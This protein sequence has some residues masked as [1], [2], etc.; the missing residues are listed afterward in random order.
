MIGYVW[1]PC[2]RHAIPS[3]KHCPWLMMALWHDCLSSPRRPWSS[4]SPRTGIH[5]VLLSYAIMESWLPC[6][7]LRGGH[8]HSTNS[9]SGLYMCC[10]V[11]F[12]RQSCHTVPFTVAWYRWRLPE[13]VLGWLRSLGYLEAIADLNLGLRGC[14]ENERKSWLDRTGWPERGGL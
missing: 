12:L 5:D 3:L 6:F 9:C 1:Q 2:C 14:S 8:R 7:F 4:P 11:T 13:A 10:A